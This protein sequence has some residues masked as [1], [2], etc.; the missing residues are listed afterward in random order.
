MLISG[1]ATIGPT[2]FG[3]ACARIGAQVLLVGQIEPEQTL[4]QLCERRRIPGQREQVSVLSAHPSYLGALNEC[5]LRLGLGPAD[6]G[7]RNVGTGGEIVTAGLKRRSQA[8]FGPV[9]FSEGYGITEPWPFGGMLCPDGHLHFEP[10]QGLMELLPLDADVPDGPATLVLTPFP[11]FRETTL[12][13]RY[14]TEDVVRPITD[15]LTCSLRHAPATSNILG[16]ARLAVR[17]DHG[18]TFPREVLE[19]LEALDEV[20]LPARCGFWAVPGGVAVEVMAPDDAAT[21]RAIQASLHEHGVSVRELYLRADRSE[22]E[23][24]FPLRGDLREVSFDH[25]AGV[26]HGR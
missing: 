23:Q 10:S 20:E 12:L 7:L 1:K 6:F 19:A 18:W 5:G 13:L 3:S 22:L 25:G 26:A 4:A 15:P 14:N 2:C 9:E 11:P 16:K 8:L 24:P 17:H 21:R